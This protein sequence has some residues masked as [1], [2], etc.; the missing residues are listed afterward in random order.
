MIETI[1][2]ILII[3]VGGVLIVGDAVR[4]IR[5]DRRRNALIEERRSTGPDERMQMLQQDET[6]RDIAD[7][8]SEFTGVPSEFILPDDS[9]GLFI[10]FTDDVDPPTL[11]AEIAARLLGRHRKASH[12]PQEWSTTV[13]MYHEAVC[14]RRAAVARGV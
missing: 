6:W 13:A 7:I 5:M 11:A 9:L 1:G 12:L 14:E 3:T 2:I 10:S 8:Y 4:T